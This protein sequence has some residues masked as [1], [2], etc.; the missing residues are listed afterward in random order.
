MKSNLGSLK[1]FLVFWFAENLDHTQHSHRRGNQIHSG[2][3]FLYEIESNIHFVLGGVTFHTKRKER[4]E[5]NPAGVKM[6]A[7][8]LL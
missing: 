4:K 2:V 7:Q 8:K 3:N 1:T 5:R 6:P